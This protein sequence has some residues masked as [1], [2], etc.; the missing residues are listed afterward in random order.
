MG[1][2][3]R[4]FGETMNIELKYKF[5]YP[6]V[7]A[8]LSALTLLFGAI[9]IS[10]RAMGL[11]M[12]PVTSAFLAA[13]ICVEKRRVASITVSA[14]LLIGEIVVGFIDYFTLTSL[15]VISVAVIIA[16]HFLKKAEKAECALLA[17]LVTAIVILATAILYILASTEASSLSEVYEEFLS[18]YAQF[19]QDTIAS[20]IEMTAE[21]ENAPAMYSPEYISSMFDSYL[22][23]IV[24]IVAIGAFFLVGLSL[25]LFTG[26]TRRYLQNPDEINTWRFMP[27][28]PF[29]YFYFAVAILSMFSTDPTDALSVSV[30]NLYLIFMFVFAYIGYVFVTALLCKNGRSRLVTSILVLALAIALSS[31]A[32]QVFAIIGAFTAVNIA[33]IKN[34]P[35]YF[36]NDTIP[37]E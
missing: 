6:S 3:I 27:T 37:K 2:N 8:V 23:Y 34:N 16:W 17:T 11:I 30:A 32:I 12:M 13:L 31:L 36:D 24:A 20:V 28:T 7:V 21:T 19:K 4:I 33:K 35:K 25:K 18:I 14:L 1:I 5:K 9:G 29:A 15:A 26:V 10:Y 22:H